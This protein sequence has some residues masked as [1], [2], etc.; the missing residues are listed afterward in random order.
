MAMSE[1]ALAIFAIAYAGIALGRL[2]GLSID[3]T[4]V[5]M[6]GA[7][8]LLVTGAISLD[9]AVAAIHVPTILLLYALMVFSAQLRLGGFYTR[10]A[11]T[12]VPLLV[13]PRRFL[14]GLM[15]VAALLSALLANDIVCLAFTPVIAAA[16]LAARVPPL[17][18]LLGLAIASNLGSAA[19]LIGNPQ[20]MLLGQVGQ[21]DFAG[22]VAWNLPPALASLTASFL[23]L[24]QIHRQAL[25]VTPAAEPAELAGDWPAFDAWQSGKGLLLLGLLLALF[26][27][28]IPRELSAIS[29]A[30]LLLAS[31]RMHTR[32]M[33]GLIDWH[34]ITLFCALFIL[35]AAFSAA[36]WPERIIAVAADASL[37]LEGGGLMAIATL[38]SNMVSNVPAC[39]L[40]Y[41]LLEPG[42]TGSWYLLAAAST[43]AGNLLL[44]GSIANL[45]VAAQARQQGIVIGLADH[46]RSGMPVTLASLL[47]L[48]LWI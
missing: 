24:C 10:T 15:A 11:L 41:P 29:L 47:L 43:Y 30:A 18:H 1:I 9:A 40:L 14:A 3:R 13:H 26:F 6:L 33:L 38:L 25:A 45:I 27:T 8:A 21:L 46:A 22:F 31:R 7:A 20:N 39:M 12:L 19:T 37:S 16:C 28:D 32:D 17:P 2:P 5:A 35:V 34:L 23:I 44:I 4:G 48:W 42:D 36:G